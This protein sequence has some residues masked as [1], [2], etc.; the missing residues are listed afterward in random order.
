MHFKTS[1]VFFSELLILQFLTFK[2]SL[3][4]KPKFVIIIFNTVVIKNEYIIC[5]NW[6]I[7]SKE[8]SSTYI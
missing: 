3:W 8:P 4:L 1:F 7:K 5:G 2:T 6:Y